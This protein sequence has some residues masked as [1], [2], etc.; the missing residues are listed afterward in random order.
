MT[1]DISLLLRAALSESE[2]EAHA[3]W[4]S[5]RDSQDIQQIP[6]S[7]QQLIPFLNGSR[8]HEWLSGDPDAGILQGI[9]RRAWTEAQVR[10]ALA[11]EAA[12]QLEQAGCEP[13]L[14]GPA[15][16]HLRNSRKESIRSISNLR[17]LVRRSAIPLAMEALRAAD[18]KSHGE[19]PASQA[20]DWSMFTSF[21]RNGVELYLHWRALPVSHAEASECERRFLEHV[22]IL[23]AGGMSFRVLEAGY[24]L[25]AA[26]AGR[27]A[28]DTDIIPWQVDA[29][30]IPRDEIVWKDWTRVASAYAREAVGR[31]AELRALGVS[32]PRVERSLLDR[33]RAWL[34]GEK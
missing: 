6:W 14:I 9:V 11:H 32:V 4:R 19:I 34:L 16:V 28:D 29:A 26:L 23:A 17:F 25:L 3:A 31:L 7:A 20:F 18:W 10:L 33:L 8:F 5:W 1:E 22:D 27:T 15:A 24:A 12:T 21:S 13:V 2:S 30:S